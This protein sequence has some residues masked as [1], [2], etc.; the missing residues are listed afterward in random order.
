[1]LS[2]IAQYTML[3]VA[4]LP[5]ELCA[6]GTCRCDT[7]FVGEAHT[8]TSCLRGAA[9]CH[10]LSRFVKTCL[11]ETN[12]CFIACHYTPCSDKV[13]LYSSCCV[14][15]ILLTSLDSTCLP[16]LCEVQAFHCCFKELRVQLVLLSCIDTKV[17]I[18]SCKCF[19]SCISWRQLQLSMVAKSYRYDCGRRCAVLVVA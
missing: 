9:M 2:C 11:Q 10:L 12:R 4:V 14:Q 7:S 1:M 8:H 6:Q 5:L 16:L 15:Q 3:L 18:V 17:I 13:C 19:A